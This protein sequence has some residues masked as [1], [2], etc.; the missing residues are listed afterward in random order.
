[1]YVKRGFL[2]EVDTEKGGELF[3]KSFIS[4]SRGEGNEGIRDV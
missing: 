3:K 2:G 4:G 1:V